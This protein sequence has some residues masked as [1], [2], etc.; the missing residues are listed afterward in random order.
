MENIY[1][2]SNSD[3]LKTNF[4]ELKFNPFCCSVICWKFCDLKVKLILFP[5]L[6]IVGS[7]IFNFIFIIVFMDLTVSQKKTVLYFIILLLVDHYVVNEAN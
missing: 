2:V 3:I 5:L 4:Q 6:Y 1:V 7:V